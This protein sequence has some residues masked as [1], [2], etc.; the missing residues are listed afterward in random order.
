MKK[1]DLEFNEAGEK[2]M[3]E[4]ESKLE[5]ERRVKRARDE[6]EVKED[7]KEGEKEYRNENNG[8]SAMI[9]EERSAADEHPGGAIGSNDP[10]GSRTANENEKWRK[11]TS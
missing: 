2:A 3:Q 7:M 11:M 6:G 8:D 10:N 9:P 4:S 5:N 1:A